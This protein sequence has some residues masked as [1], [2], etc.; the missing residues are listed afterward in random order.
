MLGPSLTATLQPDL[1]NSPASLDPSTHFKAFAI[2]CLEVYRRFSKT[3]DSALVQNKALGFCRVWSLLRR[4]KHGLKRSSWLWNI[5]RK[6]SLSWGNTQPMQCCAN[7]NWLAD[8]FWCIITLKKYRRTAGTKLA[9]AFYF[10]FSWCQFCSLSIFY[11][12]VC[13]ALSKVFNRSGT[14][15]EKIS[16][17]IYASAY[18]GH[19][20][21]LE[22]P[23]RSSSRIYL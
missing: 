21:K 15:P 19:T 10:K 1:I 7:P 11:V 8:S 3:R 13:R 5:L 2:C 14:P 22:L 18:F 23:N 20:A 17:L 9:F 4:S 6:I 12:H 16:A